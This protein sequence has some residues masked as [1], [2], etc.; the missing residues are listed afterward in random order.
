MAKVA[1]IGAGSIVF[2]QTLILDI[3][4]TPGLQDTE[5][6]LMAPSTTRTSQI[7]TFVNRVIK[8]NGLPAKVWITTDRREALKGAKYVISTFQVGGVKRVRGGLQ[9]PAQARRRSMHRR[10]DGAG[11]HLP[12]PAQ[13]PRHAST[14]PTTSRSCARMPWCSITSTRWR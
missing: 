1:I 14:W 9:A 8:E 12:R 7:E 2:C 10:H 13:H 3:L 5:F 11:R 6:A 4:G